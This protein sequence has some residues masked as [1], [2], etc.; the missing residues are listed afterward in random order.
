M[1]CIPRT[2]VADLKKFCDQLPDDAEV[3]IEYPARYGIAK[4]EY[5]PI[6]HYPDIEDT[7]M[8]E[9]MS[10]ALDFNNNRLLILHHY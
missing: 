6:I 3:F 9:S 1:N 7:D 2:T 8:I 5:D 4:G 10:L